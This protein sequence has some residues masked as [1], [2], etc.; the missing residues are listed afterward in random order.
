MKK[1]LFITN[2]ISK[3]YEISIIS[4]EKPREANVVRYAN[5]S[6]KD[7]SFSV[8][9]TEIPSLKEDEF[10][11]LDGTVKKDVPYGYCNGFSAHEVEQMLLL[12]KLDVPR[13]YAL[14][15]GEENLSGRQPLISSLCRPMKAK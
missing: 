1:T 8:V 2:L 14:E 9:E 4:F 3:D 7:Y 11:L 13:A 5:I 15:D 12:S 6:G 10:L